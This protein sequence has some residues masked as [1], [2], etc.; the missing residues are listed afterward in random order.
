MDLRRK[1]QK[2]DNSSARVYFVR[3]GMEVC[4]VLGGLAVADWLTRVPLW[5]WIALPVGKVLTSILFYVFFLKRSLRQ[6]P[7][8]GLASLVGRTAYTLAPLDP[9][10]QIKINGEI[11]PARSC[12]GDL[13]PSE[14]DVLIREVRGSILL[15]EMREIGQQSGTPIN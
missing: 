3:E 15:V 13:I 8:H 6:R 12:T 7:R 1:R 4:L 2:R 10:G 11:W 5:V 14:Q 9:D